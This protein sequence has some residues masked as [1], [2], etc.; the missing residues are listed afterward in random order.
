[1]TDH[2]VQVGDKLDGAVQEYNKTIGSLERRVLPSARKFTEHG[3]T[4]KKELQE[5]APIEITAQPPQTLELPAQARRRVAGGRA[6][7]PPR[8]S[9]RGSRKATR[10]H[11]QP[12]SRG[13]PARRRSH[14]PLAPART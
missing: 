10:L 8:L 5:L 7:G 12:S 4:P 6:F 9:R 11:G 13:N 14:R 3:I 2:F 1:M